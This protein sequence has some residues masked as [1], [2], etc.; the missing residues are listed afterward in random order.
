MN[1]QLLEETDSEKD[2]GVVFSDNLKSA[3]HYQEAYSKA[4]RMLGTDQQDNQVQE[5]RSTVESLQVNGQTSP[6]VLLNCVEPTLHQRQDAARKSSTS[7]YSV[8]SSSQ[9]SAI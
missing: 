8:V 6:G 1:G 5:S 7:L 3:A 9:K 2:L 4:N